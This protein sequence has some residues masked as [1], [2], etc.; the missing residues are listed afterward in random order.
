MV[1][2]GLDRFDLVCC[3]LPIGV[4]DLH[5]KSLNQ[6]RAPLYCKYTW[7]LNNE[8]SWDDCMS[9]QMNMGFLLFA[10]HISV[11]WTNV[12][13]IYQ[14]IWKRNTSFSWV[15]F[16][17]TLK[18]LSAHKNWFIELIAWPVVPSPWDNWIWYSYWNRNH[19]WLDRE[20]AIELGPKIISN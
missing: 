12:M 1:E 7:Y 6:L 9:K 15:G 13:Y 5:Q 17:I 16:S 20:A 8:Q 10:L 3:R 2:R 18:A 11:S 4:I 19:Q 14:P